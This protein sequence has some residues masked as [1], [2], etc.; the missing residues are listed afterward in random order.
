MN[1]IIA[2][3]HVARRRRPSLLSTASDC[4]KN[5]VIEGQKRKYR[6]CSPPGCEV[7]RKPNPFAVFFSRV[8]PPREP[9]PAFDRQVR[10][11][12]EDFFYETYRRSNTE[13]NRERDFLQNQFTASFHTAERAA[14]Y[15]PAREKPAK[16]RR[17]ETAPLKTAQKPS[18]IDTLAQD[19]SLLISCG[20]IL[21]LLLGSVIFFESFI[22]DPDPPGDSVP[23]ERF[24]AGT[25]AAEPESDEI[26]LDII[27]TFAWG[28]Y[29]VRSGDTVEGIA[30]QFGISLDAIIASN[31]ITNVRRGLIAG[32]GIRIPNM[33]GIPYTVKK[34]DSY[35]KIASSMNVP[36]EAVL[37]ANDVQNGEINPGA[38]L[39][40]PGARMRS[41]DLRNALGDSF[42]YPI[43]GRFT[44]GFG[45]RRD[46]FTGTRLFHA[47]LDLAAPAGTA[48]KA[49]AGGRISATGYNAIYGNFV[50][51]THSTDCQTM[52]GHLSR[53]IAV[54]GAYIVQGDIVGTVGNTGRSTGPHL[55]LAVYKNG[56]AVNPLEVL[57]K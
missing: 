7:L 49:A 35:E 10:G 34:G 9:K 57:S 54:K 1:D 37:D 53:I 32:S 29:T 21:A 44:S 56:R 16:E 3:Q 22:P 40:I 2:S 43:K 6:R 42:I 51:V 38:V 27:E 52:Y 8:K 28:D 47:G 17:R 18:V 50:I 24:T 20:V 5:S 55:H 19:K 31:G 4:R 36:L 30:R 14:P 23:L 26:P 46:P 11:T 48:V 25:E 15:T 41:E 45:W 13:T 12:D 39:F 33:D